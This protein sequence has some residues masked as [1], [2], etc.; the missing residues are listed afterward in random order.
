MKFI[1][2]PHPEVFVKSDSVRKRFIRILETNL[3][4]IIK[5]ETKGVEV[6]NRRDYIEVSGLDGTYRNEV[7]TAVT[8]T[9][10]IHHVLEVKQSAFADMHDIYEQCL[11]MNRELIEGKTFCVRAKRRGTHEFTS[12]ELER[13]VG[14]GLNQAVES[15]KVRLKNPEVTVKFEVENEK[16]NL[17][18]ARHKGLGGFPLGTQEDVLSLIS[19]GFDSGVS[20]YLH[21]KRG[22]KVH[23]MFFNLGGPAH[24][25]GVKQVSHFLWK[26]YGS[27]AKVKFI[28]VDFEPVVAEILEKV[29]NGQMGVILK[30]MFM[31]AGGMVAEKLGIQGLVTGE[32]L[33]QVSSQT[34]T[35]LRHIDN[36]TDTLILR[37]LINWDKED[38]INVAREIGT[39]D[40]AKTM[41]EYCGVI[42][43]KPT[44]K[45][46][47]F[48][49]E[50]EEAKF[51]F[52]ILEQVVYDARVMDIRAIE[53]ESQEQAPEVEMV[54]E[55]GSNVVV[56]DIR[57]AEEED[58]NPLEIDGVEVKHLPFFKIATQFGDLDQSKEYLLYCDRGVMSR[59]QAL[60]LIDNGYKNVKVYRP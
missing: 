32:A 60:L 51:D 12:I 3:R 21:I 15:A 16:L 6:I 22:S 13:Y 47:K 20:S 54:S 2:K 41:P 8:H 57:S 19:G 39:E 28:A 37:P 14:G 7:L 27:S 50:K 25:I 36:V 40:F 1:V 38:I 24:E 9:P 35:N 11:E 46:E 52:S 44:I 49:L 18:I 29:D 45:A 23:Y 58:E 59:L 43:K 53:T 48:K 42:S 55:L 30:R 56:L 31:R 33:G 10:G 5:R 4:S 17:V 34:L 26:K